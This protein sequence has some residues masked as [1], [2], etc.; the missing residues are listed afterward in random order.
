MDNKKIGEEIMYS[1][2]KSFIKQSG[3]SQKE[4]A[5][6]I[7][8]SQSL[9]SKRLKGECCFRASEMLLLGLTLH[10]PSQ[11]LHKVFVEEAPKNNS[12]V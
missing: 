8:I 5:S 1:T 9:F 3:Y 2:L 10:I 12:E 6:K 11:L 7:G 4:L